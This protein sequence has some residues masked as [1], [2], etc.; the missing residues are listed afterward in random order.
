MLT[1]LGCRGQPSGEKEWKV[2]QT[3]KKYGGCGMIREVGSVEGV[4]RGRI[5]L[6]L[7][8]D[9]LQPPTKVTHRNK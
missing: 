6:K 1:K 3:S 7:V 9:W 8:K 5:G 2:K 4:G